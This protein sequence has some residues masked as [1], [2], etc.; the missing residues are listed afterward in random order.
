ME[1][2]LLTLRLFLTL[3]TRKSDSTCVTLQLMAL[4][5]LIA[6]KTASGAAYSVHD[7][8]ALRTLR[9][10]PAESFQPIARAFITGTA[11]MNAPV[12]YQTYSLG[13]ATM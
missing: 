3:D 4:Q 1:C 8:S 12:K 11:K 6:G 5:A 2:M 10:F 13:T 9:F 7:Y